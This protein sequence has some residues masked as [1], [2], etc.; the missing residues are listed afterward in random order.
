MATLDSF[1]P[2]KAMD[3]R[4]TADVFGEKEGGDRKREKERKTEKHRETERNYVR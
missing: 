2:Q 1:E 4:L 3:N